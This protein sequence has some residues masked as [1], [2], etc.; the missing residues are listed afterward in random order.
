MFFKYSFSLLAFDDLITEAICFVPLSEICFCGKH[1]SF[2]TV[3][4]PAMFSNRKHNGPG[5]F[6]LPPTFCSLFRATVGVKMLSSAHQALT[7]ESLW[8]CIVWPTCLSKM[9]HYVLERVIS[10]YY[11]PLF[12]YGRG[13]GLQKG[14]KS[15]F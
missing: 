4:E 8:S 12:K 2:L 5:F 6:L 13:R 9:E 10:N 15:L 3:G 1:N 11:P 14:K 7:K